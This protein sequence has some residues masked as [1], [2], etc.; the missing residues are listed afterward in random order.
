[1]FFQKS[2]LDQMTLATKAVVQTASHVLRA[3]YFFLL[4]K[5]GDGLTP[6]PILAAIVLSMAGSRRLRRDR[7]HD[8]SQRLANWTRAIILSISVIYLVHAAT[9]LGTRGLRRVGRCALLPSVLLWSLASFV[10]ALRHGPRHH[11]AFSALKSCVGSSARHS[12]CP[13]NVQY[14]GENTRTRVYTDIA[15]L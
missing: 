13:T 2:T 7:A 4:G 12:S 9:L 15:I 14:T 5:F 6:G 8:R 11:H 1:M 3:V 10:S